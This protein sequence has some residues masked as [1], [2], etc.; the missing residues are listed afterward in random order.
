M[1]DD[2]KLHRVPREPQTVRF[3]CPRCKQVADFRVFAPDVSVDWVEMTSLADQDE[4]W[5]HN[6]LVGTAHVRSDHT[7]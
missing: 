1:S 4:V 3:A 5:M 7:C 6:G 2:P